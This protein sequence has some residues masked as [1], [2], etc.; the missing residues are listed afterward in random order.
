MRP[1]RVTAGRSKTIRLIEEHPSGLFQSNHD[2]GLDSSRSSSGTSIKQVRGPAATPALPNDRDFPESTVLARRCPS[3]L[4]FVNIHEWHSWTPR[5]LGA[6]QPT[7]RRSRRFALIL[8]GAILASAFCTSAAASQD[9]V[10]YHEN[11]LGTSL[12]LCV[13]ADSAEAARR[14]ENARS[15][16]DRS[17]RRDL[18]RLRSDERVFPL[19]GRATKSLS[20][21]PASSTTFSRQVSS[22]GTR[23]GGAFD[24]RVEVLS[25]LWERCSRLGRL[26]T[27]EETC[28]GARLSEDAGL[29]NRRD[30]A[31]GRATVG[32]PA[33]S[34]RYRQGIYRRKGLRCRAGNA[35]RVGGILLNV[36]GDLRVRGAAG[37]DHRDRR[38]L[39]R[40]RV[41]G[42]LVYIEVKEPLGRHQRQVQARI[43]RSTASGTLTSSIRDRA[44]G[45]AR[46]WR[47]GGR[48]SR[49]RRRCPRQ[50]LRRPRA[51]GEPPRWSIRCTGVDCLIITAD[52]QT[53]ASAGWHRLERRGPTLSRPGGASWAD[54]LDAQERRPTQSEADREG[55]DSPGVEQ[56]I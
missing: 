8:R 11:V 39:G 54:S 3:T 37:T 38:P 40:L 47:D 43:L 5:P 44:A 30:R 52:G 51:G 34:Q 53:A 41:V 13:R 28:R 14:A 35:R 25:R 1:P 56:G 6:S 15:R 29:A 16:R 48:R 7:M 42:T 10:F 2:T 18:Q 31:H 46:D 12:E 50:D 19:A 27:Q 20:R 4:I 24:P 33:Q 36:G 21:S 22:W 45:R 49:R 55:L 26:P 17:A 23:S 9:F 32:L